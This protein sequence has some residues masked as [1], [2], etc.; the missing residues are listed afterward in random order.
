MKK[1]APSGKLNASLQISIYIDELENWRSVTLTR[2]RDVILRA[3][4]ALTE[5]WKW[6]I[7]VWESNG[8][9]CSAAAF[10]GYVKLTF[11][12]GAYLKD[13]KRLFNASLEGRTMR[14]IDFNQGD[15]IDN[16]GVEALVRDAVA[17]NAITKRR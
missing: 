16:A 7:P 12:K 8:L 10:K 1:P 5:A 4:P 17:F 9:V 11:F 6:A 2:L 13:P 3:D 14:A 15:K